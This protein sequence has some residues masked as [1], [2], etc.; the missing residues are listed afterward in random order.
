MSRLSLTLGGSR[1]TSLDR[2]HSVPLT[3]TFTLLVVLHVT[4]ALAPRW[5]TV[6]G[7]ISAALIAT[8]VLIPLGVAAASMTNFAGYVAWCLWLIAMAVVLWRSS[9]RVDVRSRP[10]AVTTDSSVHA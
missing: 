5:M 7:L 2:A 4:R 1:G 8:G 3:A 6:L 9:S 10:A